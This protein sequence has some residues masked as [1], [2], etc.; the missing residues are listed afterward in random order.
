MC[1]GCLAPSLALPSHVLWLLAGNL[2]L[3]PPLA[4]HSPQHGGDIHTHQRS[5]GFL[6]QLPPEGTGTKSGL[7]ALAT[8]FGGSPAWR[9]AAREGGGNNLG[10]LTHG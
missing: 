4:E 7:I 3:P 2:S 9:R 5:P 8:S 1:P 6:H 10:D